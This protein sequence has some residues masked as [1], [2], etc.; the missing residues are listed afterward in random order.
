MFWFSFIP[1]H[2]FRIDGTRKTRI[3]PINVINKTIQNAATIVFVKIRF[4]NVRVS[5]IILTCENDNTSLFSFFYHWIHS[6]RLTYRIKLCYTRFT[7]FNNLIVF[8]FLF[9]S[10]LLSIQILPRSFLINEYYYGWDYI[11]ERERFL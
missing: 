3:N 8:T 7:L 11:D 5:I 9:F 10:F 1:N 6:L 4:S 2:R